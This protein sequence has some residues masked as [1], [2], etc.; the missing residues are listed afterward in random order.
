MDRR[1]LLLSGA[2]A[3]A[4]TS[5]RTPAALADAVASPRGMTREGR[6]VLDADRALFRLLEETLRAVARRGEE[7]AEAA[8]SG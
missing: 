3:M 6:D 1:R 5:D 4:A 8:R 2:A 7:M